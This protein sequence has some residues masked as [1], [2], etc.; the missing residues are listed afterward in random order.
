VDIA[1][2]VVYDGRCDAVAAQSLLDGLVAILDA[3]VANARGR[4]SQVRLIAPATERRLLAERNASAGEPPADPIVDRFEDLAARCP[5]A[6][7]V[8]AGREAITYAVPVP[9]FWWACASSD[10]PPWSSRSSPS[11]RPAACTCRSIRPTR[12][13]GCA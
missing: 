12:R 8:I 9:R 7:A 1:L 6:I 10:R 3:F 13:S 4:L 5:D 11:S 2:R